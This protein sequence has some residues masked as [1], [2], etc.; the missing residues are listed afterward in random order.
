MNFVFSSCGNDS[1]A[2]LQWAIENLNKA[3]KMYL[4][5]SNTGWAEPD[6]HKRVNEVKNY[7]ELFDIEFVEI[8]SEGM[9]HLVR[10]KKNWPMAADKMQF[11]TGELKIRPAK[12]WMDQIDPEKKAVCFVGLRKEKSKSRKNLPA[13]IKKSNRQGNRRVCFPIRD[14][15]EAERNELVLKTGLKVLKHTSDECFPC[16][17]FDKSDFIRLSKYPELIDKISIIEKKMGFTCNN[18]PRVMFRPYQHLGAI[19]IKE[20]IKWALTGRGRY[21]VECTAS[22]GSVRFKKIKQSRAYLWVG[23]KLKF[24]CQLIKFGR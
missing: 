9:E 8:H 13:Y 14:H 5:Y 22:P 11:C 16:V 19:G 6:W 24:A 10:R 12:I 15:K 17:C 18:K 20:V 2:L 7:A 4:I 23:E 1:V 21:K 3:E